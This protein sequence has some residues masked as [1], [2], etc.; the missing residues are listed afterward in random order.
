MKTMIYCAIY[1][2][3]DKPKKQPLVERPVLFTDTL[4]SEDWEIRKVYRAEEHPRMRAKY[5]KC[6]P[7]QVLDCDISIWIDGSA[8]I[9]TPYFKEWCLEKLGDNDIALFEHPERDCIYDEANYC[10][11]MPKYRDLPVL[12]QVMEYMRM[13]YPRKNGLWA[14]GLLIR[15]HNKKVQEFNRLWW[16]H[17]KKYTY[18][19]QLSFPVCAREVGL[20]VNTIDLNLW[21]ND[22]IDFNSPHKNDL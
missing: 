1:G 3:Y 11:G 7:H 18:Q 13:K 17:N 21:N 8:T 4:E 9:K 12:I 5:F 19:D 22:V 14:C 16:R 20:K 15:R 10:Q 6:M 2:D